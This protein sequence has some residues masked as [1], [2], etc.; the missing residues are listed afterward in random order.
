MK[1]SVNLIRIFI[2][3]VLLLAS[4]G[5][6]EQITPQP[7]EPAEVPVE[8][9]ME[10]PV[11][12]T[13]WYWGE[14]EAPGMK[15]FMEEAEKIYNEENPNITVDVV[16]QE[17]ETLY[18]AFRAA[19]EAGEGPDVQFFWGGVWTLED[20]WLGNL[21]P[22]EDFIPEEELANIPAG[23][24]VETFWDGEQYGWPFYQIGTF[25]A[26]NK[27][28][29]AE[30]GLDP[31]KPPETWDEWMESC[32]KL[33]AAGITPIGTGAKDGYVSAWLISYFG[34][35][36]F[37]GIEDLAKAISGESSL[38]EPKYAV[39]WH[40]LQEMIDHKCFNEDIL[41]LDLY[42][43][44]NLFE[45]EE[46]AMTN[47]VQPYIAVLERTMGAD[48]VGIMRTPI[49]GSGKWAVTIGLP[50]Q[51]LTIP[52]FSP[53][54]QEAADFMVFLHR[55]DMMKLMYNKAG[56]VTPDLR[57]K[58]E[59]YD[60][61]SDKTVQEWRGQY[62]LFWY[63]YFY[64]PVWE[65]EGVYGLSQLMLSGELTAEEAAQQWQELAEKNRRENPEQLEAYKKW[66]LPE[67]MFYPK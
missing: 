25:W 35:Q 63:Q 7:E 5:A 6:P 39:F 67:E 48:T 43:G 31:E 61:V 23:Q 20:A 12:L 56:A 57:F 18:S 53:H 16:L 14:Q 36:E 33:N 24:R 55:D 32:D 28:L 27:K 62:P 40:K 3:V 59:W 44:Q 13:V 51:T 15:D 45:L 30:A 4:C 65:F 34:Q 26:Y 49:H 42:Q 29:F 10:E 50:V 19:A 46:A 47:H 60:T 41:S 37:D 9:P 2:L 52:V 22:L 66:V 21:T 1:H 38:T 54:K 8:E 11:T 58:S 64:P 17:S